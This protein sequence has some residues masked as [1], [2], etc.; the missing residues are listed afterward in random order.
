MSPLIARVLR[1]WSPWRTA[2]AIA[3][4]ALV[5]RVAWVLCVPT[6]VVGDFAT[7]RESAQFLA[8][9][10][11]LDDGFIYMPGL[12]LL[13]A[14]I[15]RLGGEVLAAKLLGAGFGALTAVALY[16]LARAAARMTGARSP[17]ESMGAATQ[18]EASAG[19]TSHAGRPAAGRG[20]SAEAVGISVAL[21]YLLWMPGLAMASVVG[22]D[23]PCAALI[24][25]AL[26]CLF[27][28]GPRRPLVAA[29]AFGAAMGVAAWFRAVALPL[30]ALGGGYWLAARVPW[31]S[32]CT[33]TA[34]GV[35]VALAVLAPWAWRNLEHEGA[36]FF[37]DTHGGVTALMGNDPN[38]DGT[39]SRGLNDTFRQLTGRTFLSRPHRETD[40]VAYA[41]ARRWMAFQPG[42][43]LGMIALRLERLLAPERGLLYWSV[44]R[45]GILPPDATLAFNRRRAWLTGVTDAYGWLLVL[46][47]AAGISFAV[48]D[49]A[50]G[51]LVPLSFAL[52]MLATY[53]IFVAEPRYRLTSEIVTFPL[54][55]FGIARLAAAVRA[56]GRSGWASLLGTAGLLV[57]L[58]LGGVLMVSGGRLLRDHD[59]WALSVSSVDGQPRA[60]YWRPVFDP[61]DAR[62]QP[63]P[64]QGGA[65]ATTIRAAA[66]GRP[67]STV[68]LLIPDVDLPPG[69]TLAV[70]ASVSW[71][72]PGAGCSLGTATASSRSSV[73]EVSDPFAPATVF[74]TAAI[75]SSE[76]AGTTTPEHDNDSR[77]GLR[78]AV[79]LRSSPPA[80]SNATLSAERACPPPSVRISNLILTLAP[81]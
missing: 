8:E 6:I 4:V 39:Y 50:F 27:H 17:G 24:C 47:L 9:H 65:G 5:L 30:V 64:L 16:V 60:T 36:L 28:A 40:R 80:P 42:F 1:P 3:A 53:A 20:V 55:A 75:S 66:P 10:G 14:G 68:D 74:A 31:Q 58:S 73:L 81:P 70:R 44:Y 71:S 29:V 67:D 21:L 69:H 54:A 52:A 12:V 61:S 77:A 78:L 59:R 7:Y 25:V 26:A 48:Q 13:L 38:T 46:G 56:G 63:S 2:L 22:T 62:F 33:R 72:T 18:G 41:L 15:D 57:G 19:A 45:P 35:L 23:V 51:L 79:R 32:V 43:T 34:L 49:R 37:T 76:L 11:R